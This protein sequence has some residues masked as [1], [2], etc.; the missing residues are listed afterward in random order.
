MLLGKNV[1]R[2]LTS[3]WIADCMSSSE[4][5]FSLVGRDSGSKQTQGLRLIA[6]S[7]LISGET[8]LDVRMEAPDSFFSFAVSEGGSC[9]GLM[10]KPCAVTSVSFFTEA[11]FWP[12]CLYPSLP[13]CGAG[14]DSQEIKCPGSSSQCMTSGGW[15][16]STPG[17][18]PLRWNI[19]GVHVQTHG[20][21]LTGVSKPQLPTVITCL[22][23]HPLLNS[24]LSPSFLSPFHFPFP[25]QCFLGSS[26]KSSPYT[27]SLS[28]LISLSLILLLKESR[29]ETSCPF[30]RRSPS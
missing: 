3:G 16:I 29:S 4:K 12:L 21:S 9:L 19:L 14:R 11:L 1:L 23:T 13:A 25:S 7:L 5:P 27:P 22:M 6:V 8:E 20:S 26:P 17:P 18:S 24:F 10:E 28:T 30:F 15:S 2:S